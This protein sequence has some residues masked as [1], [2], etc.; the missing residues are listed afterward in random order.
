[1]SLRK[2]GMGA[3]AIAKA[4]RCKREN[5]YKAFKAAGLN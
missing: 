4:M 5:V 1:V 2:E 3:T